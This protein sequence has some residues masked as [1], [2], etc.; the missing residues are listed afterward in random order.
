[1]FPGSMKAGMACGL[2]GG[3][4]AFFALAFLFGV[5]DNGMDAVKEMAVYLL[6]AVAFFALAGGFSKTS[7][8]N[9]NALLLYAFIVIGVMF[10]VLAG[11]LAPLWF[12]TIEIV[13]GILCIIC[14]VVGGTGSYL[15]KLEKEA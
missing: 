4:V 1:M 15:A 7:Q 2:L 13:L 8:W 11:D 12:C 5:S 6:S 3:L 10:G 14:A 9:Q